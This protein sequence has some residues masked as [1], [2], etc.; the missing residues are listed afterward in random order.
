MKLC[1]FRF[2]V[3][4]FM[5][6]SFC[7]PWILVPDAGAEDQ[8]TNL[9]TGK[10]CKVN[11]TQ[12]IGHKA[13]DTV[14]EICP[15]GVVYRNDVMKKGRTIRWS[16][17]ARWQFIGPKTG[18]DDLTEAHSVLRILEKAGTAHTRSQ[19]FFV[20]CCTVSAGQRVYEAMKS[21]NASGQY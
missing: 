20:I 1:V 16:D 7:D 10:H 5:V 8:A 9:E 2:A 17:I 18:A 12:M 19:I 11:V 3:V 6:A 4:I 21:Y 13:H 14:L 15:E